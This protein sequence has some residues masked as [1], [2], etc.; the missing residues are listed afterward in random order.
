MIICLYAILQVKKL[1]ETHSFTR[2]NKCGNKH[3]T[4]GWI[5]DVVT[6]KLKS[7]VDVSPAN[8]KKWLMQ[9]YN[10]EVPYMRFF[11]GREQAYSDMHGKWD[12]SYVNIY[13]LK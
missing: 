11:R 3:A 2:S 5:I 1:L 8:L 12:D 7:D 9:I 10:V 4:Q 13:D 6:D